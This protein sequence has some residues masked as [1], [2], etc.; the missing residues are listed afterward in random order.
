M[1]TICSEAVSWQ[2][3]GAM[4]SGIGAIGAAG[5]VVWAANKAANTFDI[6]K[7]QKVESRK[8]EQAER[9]LTATYRASKALGYVRGRMIWQHELDAAREKLETSPEWAAIPAD[10]RSRRESAEAQVRRIVRTADDQKALIECLPMAKALFSD[11][12]EEAITELHHQFWII[13]TYLEAYVDDRGENQEFTTKIRAAIW[14]SGDDAND[15][16]STAVNES[17]AT[18]ENLCLPVLRS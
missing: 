18:I 2:A 13:Q 16:V 7:R 4:L 6:W 9:I 3:T 5:A 10:R 11:E 8:F 17:I 12:L 1:I 14:S 15:E